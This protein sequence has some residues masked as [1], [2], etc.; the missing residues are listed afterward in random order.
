[1]KEHIKTQIEEMKR[2]TIG[3]EVEMNSIRRDKDCRRVLRHDAL[4]KHGLLQ[5]VQ[6]MERL[7]R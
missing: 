1:M 2:Q 3:V 7:G 4:R 6:N 5:R